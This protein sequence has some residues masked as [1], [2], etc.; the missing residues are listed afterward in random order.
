MKKVFFDKIGII[1]V[2]LIG[3]SF[4]LAVRERKLA[5]EIWG[6]SL[7]GKSSQRALELGILDRKVDDLAIIAQECGLIVVSTPVLTI[8]GILAELAAHVKRE[9]IVTD[10]GSVKSFVYDAH[11]LFHHKNFIG[12]HPIAGT[13]KSGPD[14]GFSSLFDGS[15]CIL[16]PFRDTDEGKL[17]KTR[18]IWEAVGMNVVAMSPEEHDSVMANISHMP[19]A[20]AF[21]LVNSVRG[22]TVSGNKIT[23]LAGGGFRDFTRIARS[24]VVMWSDIFISNSKNII[25]S[26]EDFEESL[27]RLKRIIAD[28]EK[29][30]ITDYLEETRLVLVNNSKK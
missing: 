4:A 18:D 14:A 24:D 21:S 17:E 3:A 22:K 12:G 23:T 27:R 1:G 9:T 7:S 15:C 8:P 5:G 30:E 29:S 6:Y 2:G 19:H 20:I 16:T 13:E 26:L 25:S 10:G 11:K 28:G